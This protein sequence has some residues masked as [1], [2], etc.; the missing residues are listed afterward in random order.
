MSRDNNL[1]MSMSRDR[2]HS[3]G[4]G[5]DG[6]VDNLAQVCAHVR[7][8]MYPSVLTAS[9]NTR[10]DAR[11]PGYRKSPGRSLTV[12]CK[13]TT[14]DM[15]IVAATANACAIGVIHRGVRGLSK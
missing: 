7:L 11:L 1:N 5:E 2:L 3:D 12:D 9:Q 4:R 15:Y 6:F 8:I 13:F 10:N 14:R